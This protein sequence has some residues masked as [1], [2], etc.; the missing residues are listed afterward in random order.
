MR[1]TR[2]K[3]T[4]EGKMKQIIINEKISY[5]ECSENPL[6]ADIGIIREGDTLYS[7]ARDGYYV[8]NAQLVKEKIA[9]LKGLKA[10]YLLVSHYK[11]LICPRDAVI[12]ELEALYQS[13]DKNDA[14][15]KVK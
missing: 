14:E 10:P 4:V 6:S 12:A 2:G 13:R 1:T 11:G 5:I 8:F 15:I 3:I 7:K 9:V